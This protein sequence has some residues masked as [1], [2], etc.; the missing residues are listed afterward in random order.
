M[1]EFDTKYT[2]RTDLA[3]EA[4]AI[5]RKNKQD[6]DD[7][8]ITKTQKLHGFV[9]ES[10]EITDENGEKICG[11]PKGTYITVEVGEIWRASKESFE[12]A[13]LA[14]S[15]VLRALI[16]ENGSCLLACMGNPDIT[17]DA[18]GVLTADSFIVSRHIKKHD[19]E[20][21]K[22]L[23]LRETLCCVPGVTAKTGF[24]AA[25]CVK[26]LAESLKIDFCIVADALA[27]HKL[28]RLGT[29]VQI[30]TSG[31]CP[32][33]GVGNTRAEI[34]ERTLGIPT[35]AIGIPT[36]VEA[37]TLAL[38]VLSDAQ[39]TASHSESFDNIEEILSQNPKGFFVTPKDADHIVKDTSKLLGYALNLAL[40]ENMSFDEIDEFLS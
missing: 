39:S 5:Y 4:R 6:F 11:K 8:I 35:F 19:E 32:G 12:N 3:S 31:L 13:A 9:T 27:S 21:F 37:T 34:S 26:G 36:V 10:L 23:S 16:P 2:I 28:S 18:L 7:G 38:D 24:E 17:A 40:H 29:T 20:L 14:I 1:K 15:E 33:S 25:D 30:G 22:S